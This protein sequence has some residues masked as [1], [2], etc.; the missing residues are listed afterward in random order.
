MACLK[1]ER[2]VFMRFSADG[3]LRSTYTPAALRRFGRLRTA[4]LLPNGDLLVLSDQFG[5]EGGR[6]LRVVAR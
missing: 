6:L 1:A 4:T 2:L 5:D 3:A